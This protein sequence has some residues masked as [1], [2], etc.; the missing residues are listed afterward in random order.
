MA[1]YEVLSF[2]AKSR[3]LLFAAAPAAEGAPFL[4]YFAR[5]GGKPNPNS[6]S[7][8]RVTSAGS[9]AWAAATFPVS[10]SAPQP[11]PAHPS[12]PPSPKPPPE[13]QPTATPSPDSHPT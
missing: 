9:A 13:N 10:A 11:T 7:T 12:S 2:R 4:A 1:L 6:I 3:N 5:S 8:P